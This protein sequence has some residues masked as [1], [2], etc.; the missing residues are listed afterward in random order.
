MPITYGKRT[1]VTT[2]R[3]LVNSLCRLLL[4]YGAKIR[5]WVNTAVDPIYREETLAWL[6]SATTVCAILQDTPDD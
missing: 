1:G 4:R 5:N 6:D 3:V 2:T